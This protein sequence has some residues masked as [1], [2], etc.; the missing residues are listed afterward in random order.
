[1]RSPMEK[2]SLSNSEYLLQQGRTL[3]LRITS[4]A[5]TK[6]KSKD[7][8]AQMVE[9]EKGLILK[10]LMFS[11]LLTLLHPRDQSYRLWVAAYARLLR[12]Q[13][14]SYSTTY[15]LAPIS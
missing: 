10:M 13:G 3:N 1:M 4:T 12:S 14:A 5:S 6:G 7:W 11:S 15:P 2:S 8:W 9:S